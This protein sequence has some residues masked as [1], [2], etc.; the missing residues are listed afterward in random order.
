MTDW[1]KLPGRK[2]RNIGL[3]LIWTNR[4]FSLTAGYIIPLSIE[5][6]A[7]V[8]IYK[9]FKQ[10]GLHSPTK[11]KLKVPETSPY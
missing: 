3:L 9:S 6:F 2:A 7:T 5:S 4:P 10:N 11:K 8:N 1:Y